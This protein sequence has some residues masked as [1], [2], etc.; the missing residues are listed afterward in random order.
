[1]IKLARELRDK[2]GGRRGV[3]PPVLVSIAL[4]AVLA[5]ALMRILVLPSMELMQ[6]KRGSIP[7]ERI[8]FLRLP[9]SATGESHA[10]RDGGDGGKAGTPREIRV[11]APRSVPTSLPAVANSAKPAPREEGSGPLVG[12][13][14]A[15]RGIRPAYSD[16]RLWGP[17]ARIITGPK[18][19]AQDLDSIIA[20][21]IAPMRESEAAAAKQKDPTD[22][23]FEKGGHKWGIDK[24][25]IR[26]GPV[27]IPTA[28]LAMLPLNVQGNPNV[29]ARDRA[30]S[31]MHRDITEHAQQAISDADFKKAVRSIRERKERERASQSGAGT[32]DS[33]KSPAAEMSA[34]PSADR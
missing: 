18:T 13:G 28:L 31:Y 14:G 9:R 15:A 8:G 19:L 22:W 23:T 26:L 16:P 11:T 30:M 21:A 5:V 4:H 24:K 20:V 17:P 10:G 27:S 32:G 3:S 2:S 6:K 12:S 1:M 25:A 7:V 34:P 33:S 29:M